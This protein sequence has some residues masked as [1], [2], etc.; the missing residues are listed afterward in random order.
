M[1]TPSLEICVWV[2]NTE[3]GTNLGSK[4]MLSTNVSLTMEASEA[5]DSIQG[6]IQRQANDSRCC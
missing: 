4:Y 1:Y 3:M 6:T 5:N 2:I